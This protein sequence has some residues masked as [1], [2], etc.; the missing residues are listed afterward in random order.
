[1]GDLPVVYICSHC[2]F[3]PEIKLIEMYFI[4]LVVLPK[5][6]RFHITTSNYTNIPAWWNEAFEIL[7]NDHHQF[8][9]YSLIQLY[10]HHCRRYYSCHINI[11]WSQSYLFKIKNAMKGT[12]DPSST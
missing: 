5:S 2:Q 12:L 6:V 1:M 10:Q 3:V 11:P 8:L 9:N 7:V 4:Y